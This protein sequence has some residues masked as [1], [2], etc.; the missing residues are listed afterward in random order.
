W[1]GE[2]PVP[3]EDGMR[4]ARE[5]VLPGSWAASAMPGLAPVTRAA[6]AYYS[7]PLLTAVGVRAE[8]GVYRV[9]DVLAPDPADPE[10]EPGPDD[11]AGWLSGWEDYLRFL[12][13]RLG[14]GVDVGDVEAVAD[15]DAVD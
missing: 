7:A 4:P 13:D 5:S 8:L 15:L 10:A 12:A 14:P 6:V 9:A 2:L 3:S 1:L 11:P